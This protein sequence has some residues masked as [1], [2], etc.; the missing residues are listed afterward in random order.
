[1]LNF[2]AARAISRVEIVKDGKYFRTVHLVTAE[3]KHI[4][5]WIS[6]ANCDEKIC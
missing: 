2:L 1:M 6:V 5:G 4:Y 3:Q